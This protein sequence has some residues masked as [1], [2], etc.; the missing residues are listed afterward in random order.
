M[1]LKNYS[2]LTIKTYMQIVD[3]FLRH[4]NEKHPGIELSDGLV[5]KYLLMRFE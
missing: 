3:Y 1:I 2:S 5:Q 4:C